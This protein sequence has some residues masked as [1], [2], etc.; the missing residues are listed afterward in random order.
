MID[1]RSDT[2]T[3]PPKEMLETILSAQ[4]G[5]DVF[6]ED[7]TVIKLEELAA[8]MLGK[9]AAL[10]VT[11]GTQGN[12]ISCLTHLKRGDGIILDPEGHIYMYEVGGISAL[13]GAYPF[14]VNSKNGVINPKDILNI[15]QRSYNV[16]FTEAK[17]VCLENTHNRG[18]GK[19][20]PQDNIQTIIDIAH[21]NNIST[22]LDG[23]RIFNASVALGVKPSYLTSNFDSIQICL[24]KGLAC[25]VGSIIAGSKDFIH[26]A[27][28][29]RKMVGGGMRQ[30]GVIAAP[31]IYALTN[32]IDR[33]EE[34][35][36]HAKML[37]KALKNFPDVIVKPVDTNIVIINLEHLPFSAQNFVDRIE[38]EGVKAIVMGEKIVRFVTHYGISTTDIKFVIE[39][40]SDVFEDGMSN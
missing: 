23:A 26:K 1:L 14:L 13:V 15:V 18:G 8:K 20:I 16:H 4:L 31:G 25:P 37:E 10:L 27:R 30:A 17:L 19:I 28:K 11:S 29:N 21:D 12:L 2:V 32:M 5:D 35:H 24:S 33:L 22:H 36:K 3:L 39:V 38:Q 34:D 40:L 6:G 9:E 7:E